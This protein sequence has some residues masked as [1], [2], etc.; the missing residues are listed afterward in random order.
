MKSLKILLIFA[1]AL[2]IAGNTETKNLKD[3]YFQQESIK[4]KKLSYCT[5]LAKKVQYTKP[6]TFYYIDKAESVWNVRFLNL[7]PYGSNKFECKFF[8]VGKIGEEYVYRY[9]DYVRKLYPDQGS[10]D[11]IITKLFAYE[12]EKLIRYSQSSKT[13]KI[14]RIELETFDCDKIT[15]RFLPEERSKIYKKNCL[16]FR[17]Y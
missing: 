2:P 14:S 13:N 4:D 12:N 11:S 15:S 6:Y 1:L 8:K 5:N 10:S 3:S 17:S 7:H 16:E 9:R